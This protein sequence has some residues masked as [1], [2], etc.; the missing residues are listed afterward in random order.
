MRLKGIEEAA[1]CAECNPVT[2]GVRA[3]L[4]TIVCF[5]QAQSPTLRS[6]SRSRDKGRDKDKGRDNDK[7]R[8]KSR[9]RPGNRR[10]DDSSVAA[11]TGGRG[12]LEAEM[13]AR[14]NEMSAQL[15]REK[16][17]RQEAERKLRSADRREDAAVEEARVATKRRRE[18][19]DEVRAVLSDM[20]RTR[21]EARNPLHDR[22]L[23]VLA[24]DEVFFLSEGADESAEPW[25]P[26]PTPG[27]LP[28]PP[29]FIELHRDG[30]QH[31][32]RHLAPWVARS[33]GAYGASGASGASE[34]VGRRF[35]PVRQGGAG[36]VFP[37]LIRGQRVAAKV[38]FI[39]KH[40]C[41][42]GHR[43]EEGFA[44]HVDQCTGHGPEYKARTCED[45]LDALFH[46]AEVAVLS[47]LLAHAAC[48]TDVV[49]PL[50]V[51]SVSWRPPNHDRRREYPR[52]QAIFFEWLGDDP[53]NMTRA[54]PFDD[55]VGNGIGNGNT[56]S[57]ASWLT[58]RRLALEVMI[59][60][61][62]G[63]A[64]LHSAGV[65]HRDLKFAAF[66]V[67][68]FVFP[69]EQQHQ[70]QEATIAFVKVFDFSH[71]KIDRGD[72]RMQ[73]YDFGQGSENYPDNRD[74]ARPWASRLSASTPWLD[75]YALAKLFAK[76]VR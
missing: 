71:A 49:R 2:Q 25:V 34:A 24:P 9:S 28:R 42:Y 73:T 50:G 12:G 76:I 43:V 51:G 66:S 7:G 10:K 21:A 39:A 60:M 54:A 74:G 58:S 29:C 46:S 26:Q 36:V 44:F 47:H 23:R 20:E 32:P 63:V 13:R 56:W 18:L 11:I 70:E 31:V 14:I 4:L 30:G 37:A 62:R 41:P 1:R 16:E 55:V 33:S 35:S 72:G 6:R 64:Q 69:S 53:A 8:D 61:A 38:A 65:V 57:A 19:E 67:H 5:I 75:V 59:R 40:H 15:L 22:H 68:L 52:R 48:L 27:V 3:A 45:D 17:Q